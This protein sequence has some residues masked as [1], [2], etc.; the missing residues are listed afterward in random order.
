LQKEYDLLN[1]R[2]KDIKDNIIEK[3]G[4]IINNKIIPPENNTYY[5]MESYWYG[6][7]Q[8]ESYGRVRMIRVITILK[9][10]IIN[11]LKT[12]EHK[13]E[14]KLFILKYWEDNADKNPLAFGT[15]VIDLGMGYI[16]ET[17]IEYIDNDKKTYRNCKEFIFEVMFKSKYGW[18]GY[19]SFYL[20]P[21]SD[22][23]KFEQY[24]IEFKKYLTY[25]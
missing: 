25:N 21:I 13:D 10:E 2:I 12:L 8:Y 16:E 23:S 3:G 5:V 15:E 4:Q 14:I 17:D 1:K 22:Y 6:E 20:M 11:Q 18:H 9:D 24:N 7:S 19:M